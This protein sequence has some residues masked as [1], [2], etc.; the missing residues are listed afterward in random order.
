MVYELPTLYAPEGGQNLK[1]INDQVQDV[2]KLT[3]I[4]K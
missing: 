2:L 1:I 3:L 4:K